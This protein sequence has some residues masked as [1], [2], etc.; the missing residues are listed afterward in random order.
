MEK[1][2]IIDITDTQYSIHFVCPG[3]FRKC[4]KRKLEIKD[5]LYC[6]LAKCE[7]TGEKDVEGKYLEKYIRELLLRG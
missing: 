5:Y 6:L 1:R 2:N 4:F 3:K 7:K